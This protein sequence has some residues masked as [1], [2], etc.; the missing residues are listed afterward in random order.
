[1]KFIILFSA[2]LTSN[3]FAANVCKFSDTVEFQAAVDAGKIRITRQAD[4]LHHFNPF[5]KKVIFATI[6]S[7]KHQNVRNQTEAIELFMDMRNGKI[8]SNSGIISYYRFGN[9]SLVLAHYYPGENEYGAIVD[10]TN[11][12]TK[13]I[14]LI[15]DG[16]IDCL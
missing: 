9:Q 16:A 7:D 12:Q 2:L 4:K 11:G 6:K 14:A 5:D 13:V 15:G 1:M 8:G 10:V 3:V